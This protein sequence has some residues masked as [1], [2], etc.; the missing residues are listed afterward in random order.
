MDTPNSPEPSKEPPKKKRKRFSKLDA[1][2]YPVAQYL[3][4]NAHL[5]LAGK[6]P[7][8]LKTTAIRINEK[9]GIS[10]HKSTLSRYISKH[11]ALQSL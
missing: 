6:R 3:L 7:Q 2:Y 10:I 4:E 1:I 9:H 11:G 5:K 8:S